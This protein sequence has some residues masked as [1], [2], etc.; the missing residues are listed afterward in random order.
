M[1]IKTGPDL[2]AGPFAKRTS[3][4][5]KIASSEPKLPPPKAP[6]GV[7]IED[8]IGIQAPAEVIWEIVYD[9]E[10]WSEWN[11]TYPHAEGEI[12]IGQLITAKLALPD[13]P[14]QE[15]KPKILDWVPNQQLHWQLSFMGGMIRTLRYIE[16]EPLADHGCVVDNG[17]IFGGLMGPSLGRRMGRTVQRGF[18]AMNEALKDRAETIWATR[19]D[20]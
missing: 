4:G 6:K 17:E 16:I 20:G 1:P 11:P 19:R 7:R 2:L 5:P 9:L 13:Q 15:L 18:K 8:R 12:R 14:V 3:L 10:R